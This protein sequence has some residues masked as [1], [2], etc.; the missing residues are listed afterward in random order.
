[1]AL[2]A[3]IVAE[4]AEPFAFIRPLADGTYEPCG[5]AQDGIQALQL[6]V[7]SGPDILDMVAWP[8]DEPLIWWL[9]HDAATWLG[10]HHL[11]R[12]SPGDLA[13]KILARAGSKQAGDHAL[14]LRCAR[15]VIANR[16]KPKRVLLVETPSAYVENRGECVCVL[17]WTRVDLIDAFHRGPTLVFASDRLR[18]RFDRRWGQQVEEGERA[19]T[20][21]YSVIK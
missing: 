5:D 18:R 14:A 3:D 4:T 17:D 13:R 2:D 8:W 20:P 12:P 9:R 10:D 16:W 19:A 11:W 7:T 21:R 1:M 15:T 6:A